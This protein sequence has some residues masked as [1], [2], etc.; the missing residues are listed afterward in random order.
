MLCALATLFASNHGSAAEPIYS[1]PEETRRIRA[2]MP[3]QGRAAIY[4]YRRH[5][6][7]GGPSPAIW[8][9]RY[10]VGRLLPDTFSAL[11]VSAGRIEIRAE[12]VQTTRLPLTSE[13]GNIY[14]IRVSVI[15]TAQGPNAR[16]TRVPPDARRNELAAIR[17]LKNP[18]EIPAAPPKPRVAP[19][20]SPPA[21]PAP[22]PKAEPKGA[23]AKRISPGKFSLILKAGT[24]TLTDDIQTLFG[25]DRSFDDKASGVYA[26][27]GLYQLPHAITIG[28]EVISYSTEFTTSGLSAKHDVDVLEIFVNAKKYFRTDRRIQPFI[29]AG[30]GG[31]RTDVSGPTI[32]GAASGV[33]F[34]VMAGV[35]FRVKRVGLQAEVKHISADTEDDNS[36]KIDVSGTGIFLGVRL[37]F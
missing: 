18:R 14:L 27:E 36:E 15:Q 26:V 37:Y 7:A 23:P 8:L 16:L 22:K 11:W 32:S 29:G 24:H 5:D 33:A 28:G 3:V 25:I 13:V 17:L 12:G 2:A 20:P 1:S 31:A 35:E 21:P 6:D 4:I 19:A 10:R 9:N 30:I 34:Q